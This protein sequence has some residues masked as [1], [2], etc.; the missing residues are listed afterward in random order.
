MK[1][2]NVYTVFWTD[3]GRL[4]VP[5]NY[6]NSVYWTDKEEAIKFADRCNKSLNFITKLFAAGH[7]WRVKTLEPVK[8]NKINITA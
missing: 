7:R 5:K 3:T 8:I 2:I 4:V 1:I 6:D